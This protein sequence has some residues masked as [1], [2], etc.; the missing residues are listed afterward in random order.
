MPMPKDQ[1]AKAIEDRLCVRWKKQLLDENAA[2]V[3]VVGIKQLAGPSFGTPVVVT[4][5]GM[6]DADLAV[7]LA[8]VVAELRRGL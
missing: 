4:L 1:I 3:L 8:G 7:M 5:E 6:G 2:P